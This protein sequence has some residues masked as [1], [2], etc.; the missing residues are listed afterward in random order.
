[1]ER[2]VLLDPRKLCLAQQDTTAPLRPLQLSARYAV[3]VAVIQLFL[4]IAQQEAIAQ[5]QPTRPPAFPAIIVRRVQHDL[6]CAQEEAIAHHLQ[7]LSRATAVITVLLVP[8]VLLLALFILLGV[9]EFVEAA[10]LSVAMVYVV[11]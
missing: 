11:V 10:R 3:I 5:I 2:T 9:M 8:P 1:M 4:L 7:L 6:R